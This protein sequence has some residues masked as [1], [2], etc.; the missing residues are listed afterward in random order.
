MWRC[1]PFRVQPSLPLHPVQKPAARVQ[2]PAQHSAGMLTQTLHIC[3]LPM[4]VWA[5]LADG[6]CRWRQTGGEVKVGSRRRC[7]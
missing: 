1:V 5:E 6:S 2:P 4:Q 7:C 3:V